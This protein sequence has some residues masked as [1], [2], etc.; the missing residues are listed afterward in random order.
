M[1]G[2]WKLF[3][4]A[5]TKAPPM[6]LGGDVAELASYISNTVYGIHDKANITVTNMTSLTT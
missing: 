4:M 6:R 3:E 1:I 2:F 5:R